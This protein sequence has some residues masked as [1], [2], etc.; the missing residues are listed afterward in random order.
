MAVMT[1]N[2]AWSIAVALCL[3]VSLS[4]QVETSRDYCAFEIVVRSPEGVPVPDGSV[5]ASVGSAKP[6]ATVKSEVWHALA[7]RDIPCLKLARCQAA[8]AVGLCKL[9]GAGRTLRLK[10]SSATAP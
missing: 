9:L 4:A 2:F 6:F 7:T 3:A 5:S 1:R 8:G 10:F